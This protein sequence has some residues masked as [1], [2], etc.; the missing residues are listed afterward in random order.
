ML[1]DNIAFSFVPWLQINGL[2]CLT[3]VIPATTIVPRV[4][5]HSVLPCKWPMSSVPVVFLNKRERGKG[6][7]R[8]QKRKD[9]SSH[10]NE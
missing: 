9:I 8:Q 1:N 3:R 2:L 4:A 10:H 5:V 7:G 6:R